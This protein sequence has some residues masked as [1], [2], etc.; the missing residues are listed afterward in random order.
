MKTK[1][2]AFSLIELSIV[3]LIIGIIIAGIIQSSRLLEKARL[4]SAQSATMSS[5]VSGIPDLILWLEPTLNKSFDQN[6]IPD[7]ESLITVWKDI[8]PQTSTPSDVVQN[9]GS[10]ITPIFISNCIN[11]LPCMRFDG[12]DDRFEGEIDINPSV[13]PNL[14]IFVVHTRR[15]SYVDEYGNAGDGGYFGIVG[16]SYDG[17]MSGRYVASESANNSFYLSGPPNGFDSH[18]FIAPSE[19]SNKPTFF[20]VIFR[21]GV[22][23]GSS[24]FLNGAASSANFT[25]NKPNSAAG[26]GVGGTSGSGTDAFCGDIAEVIVYDR[27]LSAEERDSVEKY[28]SKKW[29]INISA[30]GATDGGEG[31]G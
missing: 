21:S 12:A 14:T 26:F 22:N 20:S 15:T 13:S 7:N 18:I 4:Q 30:E 3:I 16:Q 29:G 2:S 31:R 1:S 9:G 6:S 27:A 19:I 8:N 25:E 5:P 17:G 10:P 23:N 28:L 24:F 11:G